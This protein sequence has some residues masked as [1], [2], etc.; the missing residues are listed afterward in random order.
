MKIGDILYNIYVTA[1]AVPFIAGLAYLA[2]A[3][4]VTFV[5]EKK[6]DF[7]SKVEAIG[8]EYKGRRPYS[9]LM[10]LFAQDQKRL[11]KILVERQ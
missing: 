8:M 9:P 5:Q 7:G 11:C 4:S 2:V 1:L 3:G 10:P 6:Y